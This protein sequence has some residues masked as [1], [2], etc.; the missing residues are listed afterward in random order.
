M[1]ARAGQASRRLFPIRAFLCCGDGRFG[2]RHLLIGILHQRIVRRILLQELRTLGFGGLKTGAKVLQQQVS[3]FVVLLW[4]RLLRIHPHLLL[5][6]P[7]LL[8][9]GRNRVLYGARLACSRRQLPGKTATR[10]RSAL[11]PLEFPQTR[12]GIFYSRFVTL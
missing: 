9:V 10:V 1:K 5:V 6:N 7:D 11:G 12:L 8:L 2:F 4:S 3:G